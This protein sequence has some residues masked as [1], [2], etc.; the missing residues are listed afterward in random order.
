VHLGVEAGRGWLS[1]PPDSC[2]AETDSERRPTS[3]PD[4][5]GGG[6]PR[7]PNLNG[8]VQVP[9]AARTPVAPSPSVW[10]P[11]LWYRHVYAA[12]DGHS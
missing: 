9:A 7:T 11:L 12:P 6:S 4:D 1:V 2:K 5:F 10:E 3:C 8:R